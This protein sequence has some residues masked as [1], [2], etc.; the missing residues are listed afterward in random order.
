LHI[1]PARRPLAACRAALIATL[2]PDPGD[3]A[4]REEL[5][6]RIG[7]VVVERTKKKNGKQQVVRETEGGILH[8]GRENGPDLE[9]FRQEICKAYGGR[10][11]RVLDPFAG[12]G[13]IPLEAMRLGCE[14][15]AV[16]IN[17]VAWML[18]RC[19]LEYPQRLAGQVRPLPRFVLDDKE[20]LTEYLHST[21]KP[22]KKGKGK[23]APGQLAR[24]LKELSTG[25]FG[26]PAVDLAW[27]VRAWGLWVLGRARAE[28][29]RFYPV[30]DE[31]PTV[32]YLW[33][34]TVRCTACGAEVP[35]LKTRWLCKKK[36]G[37][38]RVLLT[39]E[40]RTD[41]KGVVFGVRNDVP[42]G[43]GG[44]KQRTEHDRQLGSGTMSKS[45]VRCAIPECG[46]SMDTEY[47][48]LEGQARPTRLGRVL[49]AVV[50]DGPGGKGYR[51]PTEEER[52]LA[53]VAEP[54][55]Q[56]LFAEVPF[57]APGEPVPQGA[58][59]AGGGSPFTVYLYGLTR[60]RDLFTSRQ[61]FALGTLVKSTRAARVAMQEGGYPGDW[62]EAISGYLALML[63]R[64]A[65]QSCNLAR[66][67][68]GG[69]N[70]EGVFARFALPMVW[71][72]VEVNPLASTSGGYTGALEWV[73]LVVEHLRK[74]AVG[75]PDPKALRQS[76]I[77]PVRDA[78]D[79]IIT[80]PP[81]YDA[82]PYSDLMDFFL[83]W[84]RRTLRGLSPALDE[85]FEAPLG[86]K[87]DHARNDGELIDDASR[88]ENDAARSK[89]AYEDGMCRAFRAC[90]QALRPDGRLVVVFANKTPDAWEALVSAMI[91]AGFVVD[92]SWP[93]Q[94]ER[95][96]RV[97]SLGS[98]ALASSVW[99]V[100][101]KRPATARPGFDNVVLEEMRRN[102]NDR[103]RT[104]WDAGIRGPDFIWA[105]T[106]PALEAF[107]KHPAV[108]KADRQNELMTVSD[109]LREVRRI[110]ADFVV[111]RVL[112]EQGD[113]STGLDDLTTYY[114]LHRHAFGLADVPVGASIL[115]AVS[116][117]LRDSDLADRFDLLAASGGTAEEEEEEEEG[118]EGEEEEADEA[119]DSGSKSKV[120]LKRWKQRT[121]RSLGAGADGKPAALI[122][123]VHKLMQLWDHGEQLNVNDYLEEHHLRRNP[124][125]QQVLQALIELARRPAAEGGGGD[126]SEVT[127]L[128]RLLNHV[129]SLGVD[130]VE[131]GLF[132][133]GIFPPGE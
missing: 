85:A 58:S 61:L 52:R 108:K 56:A 96:A 31:K 88:F 67:N 47:I 65:N 114:L 122:D 100:C 107:S 64:L 28:L 98:A 105:A 22:A 99:L 126:D 131:R 36:G 29:E 78:A 2:L 120:R 12:G 124:L 13:A 37:E 27:H 6:R 51:P 23:L 116:C 72:F 91:R 128:E 42:V 95:A 62:A 35:L 18:L 80:D 19:T 63:D 119:A 48:R 24:K 71:D 32:A 74:A 53:E 83:V 101:R 104:Y 121:R 115:Y 117:N 93:I 17:P 132:D 25:L 118:E 129:R 111:G 109:F 7:G 21:A 66:W 59:R 4:A 55:L 81:Y 97:R 110:V 14:A 103:L 133:G 34:R 8:W 84:M 10:A 26:P 41:G 70:I 60:W 94:T 46:V 39:M 3:R 76:A 1:W 69:E 30:V 38:K 9:F 102:I 82:I 49:T 77:V 20:F 92:G 11:P 106:G 15:T 45:S 127:L 113:R 68:L 130:R 123:Q 89:A 50:V 79:V 75:M 43:K 44:R 112:H 57:V 54:E 40:P 90:C 87:W 125:F 33:A 16:D 86:P 73:G 5:K